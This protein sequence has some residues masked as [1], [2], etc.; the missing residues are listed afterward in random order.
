MSRILRRPMFRGGP[1][2][3]Y[4]TGIASGLA[5]GGRVNYAGGGQI[6]GGTI[7]GTPMAD[8][9]YGFKKPVRFN[10]SA[11]PELT[12]GEELLKLNVAPLLN[13]EQV[14]TEQ[15]NAQTL[16]GDIKGV[17]TDTKDTKNT[18][19]EY[20]TIGTDEGKGSRFGKRTVKNP[21]YE[22]PKKIVKRKAPKT[23]E[24]TSKVVELTNAEI[25][26]DR[27]EA[28]GKGPLYAAKDIVNTNVIDQVT[29]TGEKSE[30]LEISV[31]DQI[32]QQAEIF[33]KLFSKNME[34]KNKERLKKA[35]IQDISDV[36]LDIFARSTKPG[37]DVKTMLGEAAE[38]MVDKPSRT[39]VL[40]A[41]IDD[42]GDKRYQ[43][44][45][46]LAINDY[47]AG[48][49]S[50]EATEKLLATKG[51]DLA[52]ALKTLDY[53]T[54]L[55]RILPTDDWQ[56]ALRKVSEVT[57]ESATK[58]STIKTALQQLFKKKVF[59]ENISLEEIQKNNGKDLEVGFTIVSTDKGKFIIEKFSDGS[60]KAR[61][62]LLI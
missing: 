23:G 42:Q 36:G 33:D 21:D 6:G 35:R 61:T 3:S 56:D 31:E 11:G 49:R 26:A 29:K 41:K 48:K 15:D 38:R 46:A 16:A 60:I 40:Q 12:T 28:L 25:L 22:P 51:I 44:S 30:P 57:K 20:I 55:T 27:Q 37:A 9:R 62:D 8:G 39:E 13:V 4:G 34:A 47:I 1:V 18:T 32:T 14:E 10:T 59:T 58:N 54:D 19:D 53:K 45:V 5:D 17:S 2:D 43:T 24:V 50:K 52:N 7:Y